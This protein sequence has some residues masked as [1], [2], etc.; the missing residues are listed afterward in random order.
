MIS[1]DDR[2]SLR[3]TPPTASFPF[4]FVQEHHLLPLEEVGN[5]QII[6]KC[7]VNENVRAESVD[8]L[9]LLLEAPI[10]LI[11]R[12][13][14]EVQEAIR[15]ACQERDFGMHIS[16]TIEFTKKKAIWRDL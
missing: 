10:E 6:A 15:Q 12:P 3:R 5:E 2:S 11:V 14:A 8:N 4:E 1:P 9:S 7:L 13:A 16:R